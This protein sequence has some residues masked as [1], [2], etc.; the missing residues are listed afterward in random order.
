MDVEG[1]RWGGGEME[2][3]ARCGVCDGGEGG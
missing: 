3:E 2:F 1:A